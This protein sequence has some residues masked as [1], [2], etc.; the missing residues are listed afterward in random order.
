MEQGFHINSTFILHL[1]TS[2][3]YNPI[4]CYWLPYYPRLNEQA[5]YQVSTS[6]YL[7]LGIEQYFTIPPVFSDVAQTPVQTVFHP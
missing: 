5:W 7:P 6:F 1:A 3:V 4:S 2:L